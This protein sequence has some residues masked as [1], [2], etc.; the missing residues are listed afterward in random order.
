MPS[1]Q[2][3]GVGQM[4]AGDLVTYSFQRSRWA[5]GESVDV[6]LVIETGEF[7]YANCDV[8]VLWQGYEKPSTETRQFLTLVEKIK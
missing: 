8:K 4:K 5:N 7:G 2:T 6:G 3:L 1:T